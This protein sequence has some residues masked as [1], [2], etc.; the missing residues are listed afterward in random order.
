MYTQ[1]LMEHFLEN[2]EMGK[3]GAASIRNVLNNFEIYTSFSQ[4]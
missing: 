1:K 2:F 3:N 4:T